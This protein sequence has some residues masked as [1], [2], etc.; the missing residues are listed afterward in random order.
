MSKER[1]LQQKIGSCQGCEIYTS[2]QKKAKVDNRPTNVILMQTAKSY[3][4]EG[5]TMQQIE[6]VKQSIW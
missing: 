2:I 3:C 1:C 5:T 4:P 6:M